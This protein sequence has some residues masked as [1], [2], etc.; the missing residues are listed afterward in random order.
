[1]VITAS[2]MNGGRFDPSICGAHQ[3]RFGRVLR[4]EGRISILR[5]RKID[6]EGLPPDQLRRIDLDP[7]AHFVEV[8]AELARFTF[9]VRNQFDRGRRDRQL[10]CANQAQRAVYLIARIETVRVEFQFELRALG[11]LRRRR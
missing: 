1:M 5:D 4:D 8:I 7:H 11:C 10:L 2:A 3:P 6:R 9:F